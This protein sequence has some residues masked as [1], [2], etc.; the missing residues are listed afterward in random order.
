MI[1]QISRGA[2]LALVLAAGQAS[3]DVIISNHPG[4][5]G[6]QTAGIDGSSRTKGMG[7]AMPSG[8]DYFLDSVVLRLNITNAD[9]EPRIEIFSDSGGVPGSSLTTLSN[10]SIDALGIGDYSFMPAADFVLSADTS[11]WIVASSGNGITYDW[12]ASSP[13]QTPT[14]LATHTGATFGAYPPQ[15][16][17]SILTTYMINGTAVPAP[18]AA[19]LLAVGGLAA[20]RR[21]RG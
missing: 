17:S 12:K 11:Y 6:S 18:G 10:P 7:F 4:N 13:S 2:V 5:D 14:G 9:V 15:N 8:T 21:R 20:T 16:T 3:A 1:R 19:A